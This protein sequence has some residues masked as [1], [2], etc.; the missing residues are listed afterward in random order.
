[1]K[2]NSTS[3]S[4][5]MRHWTRLGRSFNWILI[6]LVTISATGGERKEE[7]MEKTFK[8]QFSFSS[9]NV[10]VA[11]WCFVLYLTFRKEFQF[12]NSKLRNKVRS[13]IQIWEPT[14]HNWNFNK[15]CDYAEEMQ[16]LEDSWGIRTECWI[17]LYFPHSC[18][19]ND[20]NFQPVNHLAQQR[21]WS[22]VK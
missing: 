12:H 10:A 21:S 4:F 3:I 17:I 20:P 7:K 2:M 16:M 1:M 18:L 19:I 22:V 8:I 14:F 9:D 15:V 5:Q 11:T 6:C 13:N